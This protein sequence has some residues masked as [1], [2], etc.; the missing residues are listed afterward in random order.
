M[1]PK[2]TGNLTRQRLVS[3]SFI[4]CT[5]LKCTTWSVLTYVSS[6]NHNHEQARSWLVMMAFFLVQFILGSNKVT[7]LYCVA[8]CR[9]ISFLRRQGISLWYPISFKVGRHSL[10][11]PRPQVPITVPSSAVYKYLC[12]GALGS[13]QSLSCL[14]DHRLVITW[15]DNIA[16]PLQYQLPFSPW[17]LS[18]EGS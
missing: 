8:V 9:P 15:N 7:I 2:S 6:W 5:Y 11:S 10:C 18:V 14:L 4:H 17:N 1:N 12:E 16:Q 13:L 3:D